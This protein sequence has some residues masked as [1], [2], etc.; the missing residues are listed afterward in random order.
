MFFVGIFY[1]DVDLRFLW[2]KELS[3]VT[4][5]GTLEIHCRNVRVVSFLFVLFLFERLPH[6]ILLC[7]CFTPVCEYEIQTFSIVR[8]IPS[9][10]KLLNVDDDRSCTMCTEKCTHC[11]SV[12]LGTIC[13][14]ACSQIRP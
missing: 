14:N 5:D 12:F 6:C 13:V 4:F 9:K 1:V 2:E 10:R 3:T 7:N 8:V 11:R